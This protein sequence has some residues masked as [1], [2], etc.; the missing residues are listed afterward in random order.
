MQSGL[1]LKTEAA[2][3]TPHSVDFSSLFCLS[4]HNI[5]SCPEAFL[6]CSKFGPQSISFGCMLIDFKADF[7]PILSSNLHAALPPGYLHAQPHYVPFATLQQT[8]MQGQVHKQQ[9]QIA[10]L[11]FGKLW[12]SHRIP[13]VSATQTIML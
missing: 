4:S 8:D 10:S 5:V 12:K 2:T 7:V 6:V 13:H 11:M 9:C 1:L 3:V